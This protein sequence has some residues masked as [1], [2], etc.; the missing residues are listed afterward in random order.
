MDNTIL[1]VSGPLGGKGIGGDEE[2][3]RIGAALG[4]ETELS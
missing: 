4:R 1:T 3:R 2:I